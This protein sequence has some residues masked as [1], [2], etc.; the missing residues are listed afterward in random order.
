MLLATFDIKY[1]YEYFQEILG[2]IGGSLAGVFILAIFTRNA[3]AVGAFAGTLFGA[4]VP[5][6]VKH[7]GFVEVHPYLYGAIGVVTCVTV[8]FLVSAITFQQKD[9]TG[10]TIYT[11]RK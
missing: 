6:V 3:N 7:G 1:V 4:I 5:W 11:M 10:L 9:I 8:G 2:L